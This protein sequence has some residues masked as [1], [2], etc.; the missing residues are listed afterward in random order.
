MLQRWQEKLAGV[1][2]WGMDIIKTNNTLYRRHPFN[3]GSFETG[4]GAKVNR[5]WDNLPQWENESFTEP[6]WDQLLP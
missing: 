2:V 3:Q 5:G 4:H 1:H 6:Q